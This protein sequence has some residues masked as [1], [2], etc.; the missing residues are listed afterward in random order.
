MP[1]EEREDQGFSTGEDPLKAHAKF[2][3][4]QGLRDLLS[5]S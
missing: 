4:G 2:R 3:M 5:R 1:M